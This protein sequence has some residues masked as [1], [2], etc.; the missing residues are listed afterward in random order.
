[1]ENTVWEDLCKTFKNPQ[2]LIREVSRELDNKAKDFEDYMAE[3]N[4][5]D[6]RIDEI[7]Q[8]R[9]RLLD[10]Y[11]KGI[12]TEAEL[13]EAITE[14]KESVKTLQERKTALTQALKLQQ[15]QAE[16][17]KTI[18]ELA[19]EIKN[20]PDEADDEL[21][22]DLIKILVDKILIYPGEK[23]KIRIYYRIGLD[24]FNDCYL[25]R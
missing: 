25:V 22:S 11:A 1:M 18:F 14:R 23:P 5:I 10:L 12:S 21:K 13:N 17:V 19:Q 3:I 2:K 9:K 4:D 24:L 6:K 16:A 15:N 8:E 7:T 20:I